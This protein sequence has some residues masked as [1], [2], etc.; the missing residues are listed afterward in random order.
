MSYLPDVKGQTGNNHQ[1]IHLRMAQ[2]D[3]IALNVFN[4]NKIYSTMQKRAK[5]TP[6]GPRMSPARP[7]MSRN[8]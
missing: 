7:S 4:D 8:R 1:F 2:A 3:L 6:A 5:A